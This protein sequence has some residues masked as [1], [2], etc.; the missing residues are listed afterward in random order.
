LGGGDYLPNLWF[1]ISA[2]NQR[3]VVERVPILL[4]TLTPIH[5][6]SIEPM[7]GEV[8]L[9]PYLNNINWVICGGETGPGPRI[10]P[11]HPDWAGDL[12]DQCMKAGVPFFFKQWGE[13]SADYGSSED[14]DFYRNETVHK[15]KT[16]DIW[17]DTEMF[18]VG[19]KL[20]GNILDGKVWNEFPKI[21]EV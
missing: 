19:K 6:V 8:N 4:N 3:T 10:R 21:E 18:L 1:G 17:S 13:W 20:A 14:Y 12:R 15:N 7:L 2:E 5:F 11:L 16:S 9:E